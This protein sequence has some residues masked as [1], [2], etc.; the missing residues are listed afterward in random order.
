MTQA[1]IT[2]QNQQWI[3]KYIHKINNPRAQLDI[4]EL[5]ISTSHLGIC[6]DIE[7][8]AP[9]TSHQSFGRATI[10]S[11]GKLL[12]SSF[13]QALLAPLLRKSADETIPHFPLV[14]NDQIKAKKKLAHHPTRFVINMH[15]GWLRRTVHYRTMMCPCPMQT[16]QRR[17]FPIS[18]VAETCEETS[19]NFTRLVPLVWLHQTWGG[20][21]I[22]INPD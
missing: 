2:I 9:G 12:H 20:S 15:H 22:D 17:T 11:L 6:P 7:T 3:K 19:N 5:T 21:N 4:N 13:A 1:T 8:S 18:S 10:I 14:F 16:P